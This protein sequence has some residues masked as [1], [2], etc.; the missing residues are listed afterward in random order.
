MALARYH[1]PSYRFMLVVPRVGSA[2][3]MAYLA[4]QVCKFSVL[5]AGLPF[6]VLMF[7]LGGWGSES[8]CSSVDALLGATV[9]DGIPQGYLNRIRPSACPISHPGL[10]VH[11]PEDLFYHLGGNGPWIRKRRDVSSHEVEAPSGCEIEQV[12]MVSFLY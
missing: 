3:T 8:V 5:F 12:H 9:P 2:D 1:Q 4:R 6:V 10:Q 11:K 7:L